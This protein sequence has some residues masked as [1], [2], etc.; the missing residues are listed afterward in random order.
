VEDRGFGAHLAVDDLGVV[1]RDPGWLEQLQGLLDRC[2][3]VHVS[4][5]R[6]I[7]RDDVERVAGHL[8]LPAG[9][10]IGEVARPARPPRATEPPASY[11]ESLHYD[12]VSAY[13]IQAT[14]R[15]TPVTPNLW[16]DMS[17]AYRTLP[18]DLRRIVD[19]HEALH[20]IVPRPG[21]AFADLPALDKDRA[22]RRPLRVEH[23]RT[24]DELLYLP[25][26]PASL[27]DGLP[28]DE[29]ADAL[30]RLWE[31]VERLPERYEA[32]AGDDQL[33]VWDGLVTTHTNPAFPREHPLALWF[34]IV[35]Y[36]T[37]PR[38]LS[39]MMRS[40]S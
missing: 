3:V 27:V 37:A 15:A 39:S 35:P 33:F 31:H 36:G 16:V 29:G 30:R 40:Q 34:V 19:G 21:T 7:G 25:R 20:G 32:L 23:P 2:G 17:A 4:A 1:S 38:S 6:A 9:A 12:G 26:S 11:I 28:D 13:S 18:G 14:A 10:A 24:G 5:G 22:R 8:G